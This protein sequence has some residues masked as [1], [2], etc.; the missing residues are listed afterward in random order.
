MKPKPRSF[1]EIDTG[2]KPLDRLIQGR[3]KRHQLPVPRMKGC[4]LASL[5]TKTKMT[6]F[7]MPPRMATI[8]VTSVGCAFE[9]VEN[10]KLSE[11]E[12]VCNHAGTV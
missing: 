11:C 8:K 3:E 6:C 9:R 4:C 1:E 5:Q 2:N 12:L 7:Y 10:L